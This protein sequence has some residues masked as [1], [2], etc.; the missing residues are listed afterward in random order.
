MPSTSSSSSNSLR[1]HRE[2]LQLRTC[3]DWSN[4]EYVELMAGSI[5]R[6]ADFL[7]AFDTSCR[8]C[9]KVFFA[10]ST[11]ITPPPSSWSLFQPKQR[12]SV[13]RR[14]LDVEPGMITRQKTALVLG[15]RGAYVAPKFKHQSRARMAI[16]KSRGHS[17]HLPIDK[18]KQTT[19]VKF[20]EYVPIQFIGL[21]ISSYILH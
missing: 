14:D 5:K 16:F 3:A 12:P 20:Y 8:Y 19:N 7:S 17:N 9:R 11:I 15:L 18:A 2:A 6:I 1:L 21:F 4:R 10:Q 13:V